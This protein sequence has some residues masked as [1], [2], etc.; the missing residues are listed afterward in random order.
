[1]V[2]VVLNINGDI[3]GVADSPD[4]AV[5]IHRERYGESEWNESQTSDYYQ[6][7]FNSEF[8]YLERINRIYKFQLNKFYYQ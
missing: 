3:I 7:F 1:M 6:E 2:Y 5:K 8:D 4:E